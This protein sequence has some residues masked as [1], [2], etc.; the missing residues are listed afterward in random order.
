MQTES[1]TQLSAVF[2]THFSPNPFNHFLTGDGVR[3]ERGGPVGADAR[4]GGGERQVLQ[5]GHLAEP[6]RG[7]PVRD[8]GGVDG[9]RQVPHRRHQEE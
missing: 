7:V 6:A 5:E 2:K 4:A 9:G 3:A 8:G 1:K